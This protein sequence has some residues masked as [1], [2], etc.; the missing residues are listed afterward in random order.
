VPLTRRNRVRV[1]EKVHRS[2]K[3]RRRLAVTGVGVIIVLAL[4]PM[5]GDHLPFR[6]AHIE[7][8]DHLG[9]LCLS[10]LHILLAPVHGGFHVLLGGGLAYAAVDRLRAYLR[11]RRTLRS[12]PARRAL[13][14]DAFGLACQ[15]AGVPL[16]RVMIVAG[17]PNPAF[18]VGA[19]APTI[20][21]AEELA[22]ELGAE[23]L[24]AVLSHENAH[25]ERRDPLRVSLLRALS[26]TLFWIPALGRLSD[27]LREDSE[28]I[29]DDDA[30]RMSDPVVL[31]SALVSLARWPVSPTLPAGATG[32]CGGTLLERRV[33]R[34]LGEIVDVPSRVTRASLGY[35]SMALMAAWMSG[36][37]MMHPLESGDDERDHCTHHDGNAVAHLFCRM[38]AEVEHCPHSA[39]APAHQH[40]DLH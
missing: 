32:I 36:V 15:Q 25:R 27:D 9:A 33:R 2:E 22:I 37:L 14:D 11:L 26:C 7:G 28:I 30:T 17:L 5:A 39:A 4:L 21:V 20:Y 1:D 24:V 31:A 40:A 12:L 19:I 18:T 38:R 10:A 34:L 29:A 23:E 35:T 6:I 3:S 13:P 16:E 8:L